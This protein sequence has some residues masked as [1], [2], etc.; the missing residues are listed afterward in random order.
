MKVA[1]VSIFMGLWLATGAALAQ[2]WGVDAHFEASEGSV[3]L[4]SKDARPLWAALFAIGGKYGW[5]IDY[6]DPVYSGGEI[7]DAAIPEWRL[8]HPHERGLLIPA[9]TQ[10][11]VPLGREE[12]LHKFS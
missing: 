11:T 8:K 2:Q 10:L 12:D 1:G 5:A 3:T 9:G 6:E 4:V 7:R